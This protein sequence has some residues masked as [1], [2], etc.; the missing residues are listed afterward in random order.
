MELN[1][2][3]AEEAYA[4]MV[5]VLRKRFGEQDLVYEAAAERLLEIWEKPGPAVAGE[6][7]LV[8]LCLTFV[9]QR[10]IDVL[11][12]QGRLR[13][14]RVPLGDVADRRP[15]LREEEIRGLLRVQE[16]CL[17]RLPARRRMILRQYYEQGLS[18]R[19]IAWRR[20]R[21]E[22]WG[23]VRRG[24]GTAEKAAAQEE[25]RR[26]IE[27]ARKAVSRERR[28]ALEGLR[29]LVEVEAARADCPAA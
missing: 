4:A 22:K 5:R 25:R 9:E 2:S 7:H 19:E 8:G 29:L 11:R 13:Q 23:R 26:A 28:A 1:W 24:S 27:A 3:W 16:V 15:D 20:V 14:R 21:R 10:A 6:G 12:K 18:D 17:R